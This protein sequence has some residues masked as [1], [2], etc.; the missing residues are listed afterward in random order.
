MSE[1]KEVEQ[2]AAEVSELLVKLQTKKVSSVAD[3]VA[4][5]PELMR[6]AKKYKSMSGQQRKDVV[7]VAMKKAIESADLESSVRA[8]I[9][10]SIDTVIP[11]VIDELYSLKPE[12]FKA[13]I[14]KLFSCCC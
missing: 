9:M 8:T 3:L 7:L 1:T 2:F 5:V 10:F 14:S 13:G 11:P 12:D 4:L 6:T